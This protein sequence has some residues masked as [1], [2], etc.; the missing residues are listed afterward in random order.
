MIRSVYA[1]VDVEGPKFGAG[2]VLINIPIVGRVEE[3]SES[4]S[5]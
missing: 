5:A 1:R 3:D 2:A 4:R